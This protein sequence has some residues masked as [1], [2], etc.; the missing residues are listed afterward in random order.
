MDRREFVRMLGAGGLMLGVGM[1]VGAGCGEDEDIADEED[2]PDMPPEPGGEG[3]AAAPPAPD[4]E[5]D[6]G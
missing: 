2:I 5:E 1:L 6:E 4:P 3:G